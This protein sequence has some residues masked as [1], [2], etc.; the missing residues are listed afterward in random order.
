VTCQS[1]SQERLEP[2]DV[3]ANDLFT[4][5]DCDWRR[6]DAKLFQFRDRRFIRRDIAVGEGNVLRAKELLHPIAED[7]TWLREQNDRMCH[8][9]PASFL[10][11]GNRLRRVFL[12][13]VVERYQ[14]LV[15]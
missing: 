13:I 7:S 12:V 8:K 5:H 9:T 11:D 1:E 3:V 6:H 14:F 10:R 4:V 15:L 2:V